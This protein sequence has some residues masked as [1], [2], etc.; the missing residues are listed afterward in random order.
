[1]RLSVSLHRLAITDWPGVIKW[2]Q[3]ADRLGVHSMW[4]AEA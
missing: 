1:M 4:T 2:A 3:E